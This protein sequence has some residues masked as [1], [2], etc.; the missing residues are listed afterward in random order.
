MKKYIVAAALIALPLAGCQRREMAELR[1]RVLKLENDVSEIKE[2]GVNTVNPDEAKKKQLETL[3]QAFNK[4]EE[5]SYIDDPKAKAGEGSVEVII[6]TREGPAYMQ[7]RTKPAEADGI[8]GVSVYITDSKLPKVTTKAKGPV[9]VGYLKAGNYTVELEKKGYQKKIFP[10]EIKEGKQKTLVT[11]LL[12]DGEEVGTNTA[13]VLSQLGAAQGGA[14]AGG[15]QAGG[16]PAPA[17]G[18]DQVKDFMAKLQEAAQR[19]K[20]QQ[21][22]Q[23]APAK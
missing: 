1:E 11:F 16:A 7:A 5:K 17:M 12:K 4:L 10:L 6:T 14:P 22:Q 9:R 18:A 3:I 20:Q 23:Q 21:A 13:Q 2:K 19:A 15:D 8:E